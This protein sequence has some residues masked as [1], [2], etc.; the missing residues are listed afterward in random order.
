MWDIESFKNGLEYLDGLYR[1]RLDKIR[2]LDIDTGDLIRGLNVGDAK[3]YLLEY[4]G[5]GEYKA[6]GIDGSMEYTVGLDVITMFVAVAGYTLKFRIGREGDITLNFSDVEKMDAYSIFK[7]I[8]FWFEDLNAFSGVS[9]LLDDRSLGK[10]IESIPRSVM[11][12]GEFLFAYRALK[13]GD[14]K[15][16]FLDRPIASSYG[17]YFRDAREL[18]L[19]YRGGIFTSEGSPLGPIP[20]RDLY[21]AIY[22][23]PDPSMISI[24]YR[25]GY[26]MHYI[27]NKMVNLAYETGSEE[28]DVHMLMKYLPDRVS[29]DRLLK[30]L[31]Q[32]NN[33]FL[34]GSLIDDISL[35]RVVLNRGIYRYWDNAFKLVDVF[36]RSLLYGGVGQHPLYI[37]GKPMTVKEINTLTLLLLY[38]LKRV[39]EEVGGLIIGIGKD[40]SVTDLNRSVIPYLKSVGSSINIET[41]STKSDRNMLNILSALFRDKFPTPWRTAGYDNIFSSLI[42]DGSDLIPARRKAGVSSLL[43]RNYFQLREVRYL[44]DLYIRSPIFFYDRFIRD[45]D[46]N[47]MRDVELRHVTGKYRSK[48]YLE[49]PESNPL[50]NMILYI[51]RAFDNDQ[52]IESAGHNYLLFIADKE[53][54]RMIKTIRSSVSKVVENTMYRMIRRYNIYI[55]TKSFREY[56]AQLERRRRR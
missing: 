47:F 1:D 5:E 3:K 39:E 45:G 18:I 11:T 9:N 36:T 15:I 55:L 17:P 13:S 54:K 53:V 32:F 27:I 31:D 34:D 22:F 2:D 35:N 52:I 24:E 4:F 44:D 33:E 14:I 6:L 29:I 23:G 30:K 12:F 28:I 42:H 10:S 50:D 48:I 7:V 19:R 37:N 46:K 21:L 16:V 56:R 40:T 26:K 20:L 8:P 51:L 41:V 25:P 49:F 38:E 43:V